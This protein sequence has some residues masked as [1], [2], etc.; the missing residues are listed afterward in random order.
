M[1]AWQGC[2]VLWKQFPMGLLN[3]FSVQNAQSTAKMTKPLI[4][5]NLWAKMHQTVG[6]VLTT[7][8]YSN[9]PQNMTQARDIIDQALATAMHAMWTTVATTLVSTPGAL[10]F[11][12]GIN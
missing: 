10:A 4:K 11:S 9:P 1:Y 6:N 7:Y 12:Q 5:F 3:I 8:L 2:W